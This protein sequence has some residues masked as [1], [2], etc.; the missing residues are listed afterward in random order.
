MPLTLDEIKSLV[1]ALGVKIPEE[2]LA[3]KAKAEEFKARREEML[4]KAGIK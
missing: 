2:I 3:Q 1:A 4:K